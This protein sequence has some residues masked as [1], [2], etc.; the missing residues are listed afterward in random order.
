MFFFSF[1]KHLFLLN[2]FIFQTSLFTSISLKETALLISLGIQK[3]NWAN[4][5]ILSN[6]YLLL[7]IILCLFYFFYKKLY[8]LYHSEN[9]YFKIQKG[10]LF[11]SKIYKSKID[12]T[13]AK[14]T[15]NLEEKFNQK[16][17]TSFKKNNSEILENE[18]QI[19]TPQKEKLKALKNIKTE[20]NEVLSSK[21]LD[22][23]NNV[24]ENINV[25]IEDSY[26]KENVVLGRIESHYLD[27][28]HKLKKMHPNLSKTDIRHCILVKNDFSLKESA[29]M[30]SVTINTVKKGRS[31]AKNKID[32]T[33]NTLL[34][35]YLNTI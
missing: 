13:L 5:I 31:R 21:D 6:K 8:L 15:T 20:L 19:L 26:T 28:Y 9:K 7:I 22:K 29:E 2:L 30:L 24:K 32:I 25:I 17:Y 16:E 11:F 35:E 34:R 10:K 27:L 18:L 4:F 33:P 14:D 1:I 12:E 3:E 23:L